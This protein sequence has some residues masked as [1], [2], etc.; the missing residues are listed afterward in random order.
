MKGN[1]KILTIAVLLLFIAVS[2]GTYAIYKSSATGTGSVNAAAWVIKVQS[3]SQSEADIVQNNTFTLDDITWDTNN[4]IGQNGTIAP[5]DTGTVAIK[6]DADGSEVAVGYNVVIDTTA[7]NNPNFT[8]T[9]DTSNGGDPLTGTIA[10][11]ATSGAM[12][13]N[14]TLKV[15]WTGVDETQAN[16][17]DVLLQGTQLSIPVTVTV[18]QSPNPAAQAQP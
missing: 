16:N 13:K 10:Y 5:G 8:V 1:K 9:A 11:S 12:E 17:A 4:R 7:L 3:G 2:F 6:I 18:T 14:I 15:T